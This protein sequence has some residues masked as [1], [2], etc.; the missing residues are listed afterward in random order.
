MSEDIEG[1]IE[2][3]AYYDENGVAFEPDDDSS[4]ITID[5]IDEP[6]IVTDSLLKVTE[7]PVEA[8]PEIA[9]S[10]SD[11][12]IDEDKEKNDELQLKINELTKRLKSQVGDWYVVHSYVGYETK[13]K[14]NLEKAMKTLKYGYNIYEVL[15]PEQEEIEYTKGKKKVVKRVRIPSYV[16]VRMDMDDDTWAI[17]RNTAGVT[18][19]VGRSRQPVPLRVREVV[20]MIAPTLIP[21]EIETEEG[22]KKIRQKHKIINVDFG[23]GETVIVQDGPFETMQ[24]QV[25]EINPEAGK[26]TVLVSI[27]GRETPVELN[28]GQVRK[29]EDVLEDA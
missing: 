27:F 15:V 5:A 11:A 8:L 29:F 10:E 21:V 7:T 26:L 19:F 24:G 17:V 1:V 16:L 4:I 12:E 22:K 13:V 18:G 3:T 6:L 2:D 9:E 25:S 28:F 20:D 14:Q 23:V